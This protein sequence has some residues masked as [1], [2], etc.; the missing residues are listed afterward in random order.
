MKNSRQTLAVKEFKVPVVKLSFK[1]STE[2]E[3]LEN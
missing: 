3:H 1:D 2:A